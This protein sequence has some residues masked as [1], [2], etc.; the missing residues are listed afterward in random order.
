MTREAAP[1]HGD[2][3]A[4]ARPLLATLLELEGTKGCAQQRCSSKHGIVCEF[5]DRR[6][7]RCHTA[8]CPE[9]RLVIDGRVYCRRHAAVVNALPALASGDVPP[10]PDLDDRAP[11]LAGWVARDIDTGVR[12]VIASALAVDA[13]TVQSLPVVLTLSGPERRRAW[14]HAWHGIGTHGHSLRVAVLVEEAGNGEVR[15]CV[16]GEDC[17]RLLPPWISQRGIGPDDARRHAFN[18]ALIDALDA[19]LRDRRGEDPA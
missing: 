19:H 1:A 10:P 2:G 8:W 11:S 13:T 7:R 14:E 16:D 12:D 9:H 3:G 4:D 15:L 5:V 18:A 17:V 6:N